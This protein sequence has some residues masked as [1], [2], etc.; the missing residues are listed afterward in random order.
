MDAW[1]GRMEKL[2]A[3]IKRR[4]EKISGDERTALQREA[5]QLRLIAD[6]FFDEVEAIETRMSKA[7]PGVDFIPENGFSAGVRLRKSV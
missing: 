6:T 3:D 1:A 2:R 5:A 7:S 4:P